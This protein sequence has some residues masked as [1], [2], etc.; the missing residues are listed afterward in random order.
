VLTGGAGAA[1]QLGVVRRNAGEQSS[2]SPD[3]EVR[4]DADEQS[5]SSPRSASPREDAD[6]D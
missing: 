6:E 1:L 3:S 2:P 5:S 4:Q